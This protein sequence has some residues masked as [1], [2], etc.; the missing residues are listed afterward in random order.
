[1]AKGHPNGR[2]TRVI[3]DN[4]GLSLGLPPQRSRPTR[5]PQGWIGLDEGR[6]GANWVPQKAICRRPVAR[7]LTWC[8]ESRRI[9]DIAQKPAT[10]CCRSLDILCLGLFPLGE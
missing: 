3:Q 7:R 4:V 5:M 9:L 8:L 6:S 1:M 2:D 10:L